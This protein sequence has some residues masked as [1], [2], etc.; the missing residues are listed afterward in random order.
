MSA[1]INPVQLSDPPP[2]GAAPGLHGPLASNRKPARVSQQPVTLEVRRQATVAG[3]PPG[4]IKQS[5]PQPAVPPA[6]ADGAKLPSKRRSTWRSQLGLSL[7][8]LMIIA[9]LVLPTERYVNPQYGIG[10]VLGILGGSMMLALL[11][12]P[13]RKRSR[14]LAFLGSIA[15]WFR[16]HMVLGVVGPL[17]ILYHSNFSFGATNSNVALAC[18]LIVAGSGLVGR[19]LYARI[20]HGLYGRRASLNELARDAERLR[21]HSGQL[22]LLPGLMD[23]IERAEK[24][25]GAPSITLVR[26]FLA[27]WRQKSELRR[28]GRLLHHAVGI[29]AAG[30][31]VVGEQRE[32]LTQAALRYVEARLLAARRVAEFES[33]ERLFAA[34][35][36]LH[37]PLFLMLVV[38][39]IVHV[40]AVHMY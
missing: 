14:S 3:Q 18:M 5:A 23:E 21:Q 20:H 12:Y 7:A 9:G 4:R 11:I 26:P 35:H 8:A 28:M 37:M 25:I 27:A 1:V 38:V 39:G 34:W 15:G 22:R 30:S 10:Y 6:E 29:A 31:V 13:L 36:V 40:F 17:A 33:S 19:Y 2:T 16:V 32:R 24:H